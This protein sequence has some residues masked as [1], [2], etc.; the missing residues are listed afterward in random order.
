[1]LFKILSL[2]F[3]DT[4][5]TSKSKTLYK[6]LPRGLNQARRKGG[7]GVSYPGP[8]NVWGGAPSA[9]NIE[10]TILKRT[11]QKFSLQRALWKCLG[12]QRKCFPGPRCGSRR[13]WPGQQLHA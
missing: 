13:A 4:V 10:C 11:I 8:R 9:R 6:P 1:M 5:D 2:A 12:A 3:S 7:V